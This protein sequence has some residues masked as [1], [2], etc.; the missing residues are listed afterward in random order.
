MFPFFPFSF[1]TGLNMDRLLKATTAIYIE[2][3]LYVQ[4]NRATGQ[5]D[6]K[7]PIACILLWHGKEIISSIV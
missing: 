3:K 5:K 6:P 2:K 7:A 4:E 1:L